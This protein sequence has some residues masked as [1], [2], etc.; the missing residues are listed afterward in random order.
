MRTTLRV[1]LI[2]DSS[3]PAETM[4]GHLRAAGFEPDM[5]YVSS[6]QALREA[7]SESQWDIVI[8]S[9]RLSG[10][11]A[12]AALRVVQDTV[13]DLPFI[14]YSGLEDE[15]AAIECLR[16]GAA[17]YLSGDHLARLGPVI[18]REVR[19]AAGRRDRKLMESALRKREASARRIVAASSEGTVVVDGKRLVR[20]LNPAAETMLGRDAERLLGRELPL[21]LDGASGSSEVDMLPVC[22]VPII[23]EVRWSAID[24][25][26]EEATLVILHDV[27]IRRR[28]EAQLRDSFV[29]LA[30]TLSRAMASR[31]PYTTN[32]QQRV[33]GLVLQVGA[34]M[35]LKDAQ[36]W[37]L[38][39]GGL[40]HD[41]GKVAVPET[42]LTKPGRLTPEEL[43]I[44]RTHPQQGYDI[45]KDAGL[46]PAVA[47]MALHHHESLDGT[48]YPQGLSGN[49]LTLQDRILTASNVLESLTSFRPYR[50]AFTV[51]RALSTLREG[52]GRQFD[53]DV[54]DC[55]HGL[56]SAGA[57]QPGLP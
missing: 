12:L 9:Y 56:V 4:R 57:Y 51:E 25:G 16:A 15:D 44:V 45:L 46:P 6:E 40:L 32:H 19:V 50:R 49:A 20:Y 35:G 41:V 14:V 22:G 21:G 7:L 52:V 54:V 11:S 38:R 55:L 34:R 53:A 42:L 17:D 13:R 28:A 8:S 18:A 5:R 24:W 29:T 43:E 33:A 39:L 27:T 3:E 26:G 37:E 23:V 10:M 1:L 31:D 47:L 48:G 36:L 30:D 2:E